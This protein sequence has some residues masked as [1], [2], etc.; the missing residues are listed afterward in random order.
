MLEG[1]LHVHFEDVADALPLEPDVQVSRLN[2]L[3]SQT[4]QVT[5]TSA[6]KSISSRFEPFPSQASQRPPATL[7]LNRPALVASGLRLGKPGVEVADQVEQLDIRGRVRPRR[8]AD[9]RLVDVDDLVEMIEPRRSG[10]AAPG[11]VIAP[12]RS[13]A[14]VSRRMSPTS[15]LL[16]EPLTPVTQTNRPSG[17]DDV[18]PLEVVAA[19]PRRSSAVG[20]SG[21]LRSS[22]TAIDLRPERYCAGQARGGLGRGRD[23]SPAATTSP[24]L[25]PGPGPKS[26]RWSAARIVS[27]SC[28]TTMTVLPTSRSRCRV[29]ISRSLSRGWRPIEGS[30]RM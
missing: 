2:R 28:S 18:D 8:P 1:L 5:Q 4:G 27:S 21:A 15:E 17:N 19:G 12:L 22:G 10:R 24:P 16:P 26:T 30:S 23:A 20:P 11:S 7:K 6:R 13:R 9:R 3:P 29:A 14:R 25:T